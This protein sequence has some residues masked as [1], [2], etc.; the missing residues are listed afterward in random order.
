MADGIP[1]AERS[2][3]WRAGI[4]QRLAA[5][6]LAGDSIHVSVA[7]DYELVWLDCFEDGEQVAQLEFA[8]EQAIDIAAEIL[9]HALMA[10]RK[11]GVAKPR[12][13]VVDEG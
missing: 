6:E 10:Q 5:I 7:P 12:L 4:A 8:P 11:R 2:R 13:Q 3:R 1:Q 9:V